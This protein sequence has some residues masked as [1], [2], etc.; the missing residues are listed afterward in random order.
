MDWQLLAQAINLIGCIVYHTT[1]AVLSLPWTILFYLGLRQ[2]SDTG[3]PPE[4]ATFYEGNVVHIRRAPRVNKFRYAVRMAVLDLDRPPAW[5][6]RSQAADH[7]TAD[8]ARAF[9]GTDGPVKLLTDPISAGYVQNPISV[10][11]CYSRAEETGQAQGK[12]GGGKAA[13]KVAAAAQGGEGTPRLERCIAE[14]TNTPWNERVTFVFDPAGQSVRKALHVSPFMDMQNT[15]HLEAPE[16]RDTLKLVVR[17]TH[18]VH[19]DYFY[20]DLL[21]RAAPP[22]RRAAR[23]EE[24]GLGVALSYAFMPHRVALLIY[25]Q[26]VK[27]LVKGVPFYPPPSKEYQRQLLEN[28]EGQGAAGESRGA[29]EVLVAH[30]AQPNGHSHGDSMGSKGA[31]GAAA[32]AQPTLGGG[33]CPVG[34]G[35]VPGA[36]QHTHPR[37]GVD[38]KHFVW[39]PAPGWPWRE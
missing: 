26:A 19:G 16:P 33:L 8:Q 20:A 1:A 18:P 28:G 14:V 2:R 4:S 21:A 25:W 10:Y 31:N 30:K 39:R 11:Y 34:L 22:G 17:A 13:D 24:A 36:R 6:A 9:A 15:W 38:G 32:R 23:N 12:G 35:A 29:G 27:L 7:M 37:N 5:F 3:D